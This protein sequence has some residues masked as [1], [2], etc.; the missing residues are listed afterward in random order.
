MASRPAPRPGSDRLGE[1]LVAAGAAFVGLALAFATIPVV[2]V[3]PSAGILLAVILAT[4]YALVRAPGWAVPLYLGV[5]WAILPGSLF[6]G[7]PSP[8]ELGGL[9]L[10]GYA[11]WRAA[12]APEVGR[13]VGL[14]MLFFGLPLWISAL[15]SPAAPAIPTEELRDL[16][17]VAIAGLCLVS[18]RDVERSLTAIAVCGLVLG[19]GALASILIGPSKLFPLAIDPFGVEA[20]RAAGPFGEP[21][22]F[23]LSLATTMPLQYLLVLRHG[24][25]QVVGVLGII[26]VLGGIVA[27]GSRGS[28]VAALAG[29][30]LSVVWARPAAQSAWRSRGLALGALA[31]AGVVLAMSLQAQIQSSSERTVSGRASENRI[32]LAMFA[33]R[34]VPG[35]GANQYAVRYREYSRRIGDD[36]RPQREAHNLYLEVL[37]EQGLIG[38]LGWLGALV[39]V[40]GLLRRSGA[41]QH[42]L[43]RALT[44]ALATYGVG[45]IFLH[46][47][48]LRLLY[49]L[50]GIAIALA[51]ALLRESAPPRRRATA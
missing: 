44:L 29:L 47:S 34:P 12:A 6:G 18:V 13:T 51:F 45:S 11:V 8:V 4:A 37:A 21:N 7:L 19:L 42:P 36:P 31:L 43:G 2:A 50:I 26:A 9:A 40:G 3:R 1:P 32:A 35:V 17:F 5:V 22:F 25:W 48:V 30:L 41:W 33:D 46:G 16:L 49:V 28:L 38:A 27:A 15:L 20:P 10:T 23:A 14:V 24:R 39:L